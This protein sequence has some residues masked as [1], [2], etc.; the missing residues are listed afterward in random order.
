MPVEC[1]ETLNPTVY[2]YT[3]LPSMKKSLILCIF[4]LSALTASAACPA[5]V[6]QQ[7]TDIQGT[8]K[9][10]AQQ[11]A[12]SDVPQPMTAVTGHAIVQRSPRLI[13]RL[14]TGDPGLT[15]GD[16]DVTI[17]TMQQPTA[18]PTSVPQD[19]RALFDINGI[20]NIEIK[21]ILQ[22][23]LTQEHVESLNKMIDTG[24][25]VSQQRLTLEQYKIGM[26]MDA[27]KHEQNKD[28]LF[29]LAVLALPASLIA[30]YVINKF[31][32]TT[33]EIEREKQRILDGYKGE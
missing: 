20:D 14:P 11:Q 18:L 31:R 27:K 3:P 26:E 16:V 8:L 28:L 12:L 6:T 25:L 29:L 22:Q 10:M 30:S 23:D 17:V 9:N 13:G 33:V 32:K 15:G 21:G 1:R 19:S 5:V 2:K 7:Q 4:G 24:S